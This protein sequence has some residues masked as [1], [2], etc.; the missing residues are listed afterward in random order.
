[1]NVLYVVIGKLNKGLTQHNSSRSEDDS[2]MPVYLHSL[3]STNSSLGGH[4]CGDLSSHVDYG[5]K[6]LQGQ[7]WN[8]HAFCVSSSCAEQQLARLPLPAFSSLQQIHPRYPHFEMPH[9]MSVPLSS[10][11]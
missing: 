7:L 1:M 6:S 5:S 2:Q 11:R 9:L 8:R 3:C 10:S 4:I